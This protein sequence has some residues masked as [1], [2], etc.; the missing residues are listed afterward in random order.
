MDPL[1]NV[2]GKSVKSFKIAIFYYITLPLVL[3]LI[4]S[5]SLCDYSLILLNCVLNSIIRF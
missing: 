2:L 4:Y 1:A 5:F 3:V